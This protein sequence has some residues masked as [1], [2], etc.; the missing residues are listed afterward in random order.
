[1]SEHE[2]SIEAFREIEY[3]SEKLRLG[4]LVVVL[5]VSA[6]FLCCSGVGRRI[7]APT[8]QVAP[9]SISTVDVAGG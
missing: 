6:V 4:F 2:R 8:T 5:V 9:V 1:M 7:V 3:A